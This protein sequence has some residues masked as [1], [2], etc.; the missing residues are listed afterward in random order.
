MPRGSDFEARWTEGAWA[1]TKILDALNAE[2]ELLA[3]QFGITVGTAFWSSKEMEARDLPDQSQHGKRPDILVFVRK[4]MTNSELTEAAELLY[5][6][7]DGA[8]RLARRAALAIE[9][10]FS[11]YAYKHRLEGYGKELSFTIKDEDL[12]PL[13][14]WHKHFEV[15]L[16]IVQIYFDSCYF[17]A[18]K[19]LVDGIT[20]GAIKGQIERAYKKLVYYPKM[21]TGISFGEYSE[22]PI[23]GADV[24]LDKYG[25]YTPLRKVIG[26]KIKLTKEMREILIPR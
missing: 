26:G 14:K 22:A 20:S 13:K 10:E 5:Q 19:S 2:P 8:E 11:P 24:I 15:P 21:S 4:G 17:L 6:S 16:G 3:V 7:D 25:K 23:M 1:E 9:S 18:F 12:E